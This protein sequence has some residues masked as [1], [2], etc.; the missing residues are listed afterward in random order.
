VAVAPDAVRHLALRAAPLDLPPGAQQYGALQPLQYDAAPRAA[1]VVPKQ[2]HPGWVAS[3][4]A[5]P[6]LGALFRPADYQVQYAS[7]GA[8]EAAAASSPQEIVREMM[9]TVL[10]AA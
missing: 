7:T 4:G 8:V 1:K 9:A 6:Q 3:R 2:L 10:Y 5:R